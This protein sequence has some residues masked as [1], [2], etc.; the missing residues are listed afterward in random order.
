MSNFDDTTKE[1][2]KGHNFNQLLMSDHPY[3]ILTIGGFRFGKTNSSFDLISQ[4]P[5]IEKSYLY[6]KDPYEAKY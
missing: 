5:D 3:R 1:N 6:D 2:M 4:Q